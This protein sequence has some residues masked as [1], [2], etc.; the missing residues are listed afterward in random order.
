MDQSKQRGKPNVIQ[1]E[2]LMS[3]DY[4]WGIVYLLKNALF[5]NSR[6]YWHGFIE[7]AL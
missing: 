1:G 4:V 5:V 6:I 7:E 3:F 2:S